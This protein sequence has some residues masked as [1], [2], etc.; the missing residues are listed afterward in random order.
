[1]AVQWEYKV[2]PLTINFRALLEPKGFLRILMVVRKLC[3][4]RGSCNLYTH[5][6]FGCNRVLHG[7][8]YVDNIGSMRK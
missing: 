2:G 3:L 1:M 5:H 8:K 7:L 6:A 4:D